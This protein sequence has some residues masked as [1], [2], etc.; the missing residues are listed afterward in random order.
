MTEAISRAGTGNYL[1]Q[2]KGAVAAADSFLAVLLKIG[3][4]NIPLHDI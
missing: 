3:F 4:A 2:I 1:R